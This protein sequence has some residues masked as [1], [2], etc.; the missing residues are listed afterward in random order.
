MVTFNF[1]LTVVDGRT[2]SPDQYG[3]AIYNGNGGALYKQ[4]PLRI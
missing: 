1:F 3:V 4:I 2:T